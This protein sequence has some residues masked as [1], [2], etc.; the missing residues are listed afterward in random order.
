MTNFR[1]DSQ[2]RQQSPTADSKQPAESAA[3]VETKPATSTGT[4]DMTKAAKAMGLDEAKGAD[5]KKNPRDNPDLDKL[6]DGT[7]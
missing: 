7:P 4:P 1:V 3:T 5:P 6:L 2:R